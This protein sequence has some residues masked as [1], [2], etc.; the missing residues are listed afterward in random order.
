MERRWFVASLAYAATGCLSLPSEDS[1]PGYVSRLP[2]AASEGFDHHDVTAIREDDRLEVTDYSAPR[3]FV[4]TPGI[5]AD[6]LNDVVSFGERRGTAVA[7]GGFDTEAVAE[8]LTSEGFDEGDEYAGARTFENPAGVVV[9]VDG[10]FCA[11]SVTG[12]VRQAVD[13]SRGD[14]KPLPERDEAFG[15]LVDGLGN[16][17]FVTGETTNGVDV[18]ARGKA[19]R[20][21]RNEPTA[22]VVRVRVYRSRSGVR[23]ATATNATMNGTG[24]TTNR[25]V[26]VTANETGLINPEVETD[27][28]VVRVTGR[29]PVE[30]L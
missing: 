6:D 2:D 18:V 21:A 12:G 10:S 15:L 3:S 9:A 11:R 29:V 22:Q 8:G 4:D 25:T 30:A 13:V 19:V 5:S 20:T 7:S 23:N 27:G 17:T 16:G 24:N 1:T 28:R 26:N 14:K